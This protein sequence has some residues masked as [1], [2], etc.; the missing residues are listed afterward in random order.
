MTNDFNIRDSD[1]DPNIHYYFFCPIVL[2]NTTGKLIEKIIN[3]YL[4]FYITANGFLD[5]NQLDG[6]RQ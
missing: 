5:S 6:I 3:N 1:W 4:Q 2:L